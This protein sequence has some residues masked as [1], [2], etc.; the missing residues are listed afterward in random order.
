MH[1]TASADA[2]LWRNT[3]S[4]RVP[5]TSTFASLKTWV[6]HYTTKDSVIFLM[7][8]ILSIS[9]SRAEEGEFLFLALERALTT[10]TA[11]SQIARSLVYK[12]THKMHPHLAG[13]LQERFRREQ[14]NVEAARIFTTLVQAKQRRREVWVDYYPPNRAE[15]SRWHIRPYRFVSNPLSDGFYVLCDGSRD[16]EAYISLSL[17]FDRIQ[18]VQLCDEHFEIAD[19]A[20]FRSH[21]GRA[22]GVWDSARKPVAVVLRFE[23]RHYDRLLESVWHPT[24]SIHTDTDRYV[25]YR[26][27]ISQPE[28]MV[29]WIRSWGSGVVVEEPPELRRRI[30]HSV[31]R[32]T[33]Q[34]GLALDG[35]ANRGSLLYRLWAKREPRGKQETTSCHLLVYHL[36]DVA[37]ASVCMWDK[38]LGERQKAWLQKTLGL[39]AA[40][41]RQLLAL[42]AGLHDIGKA[43]PAFQKKSAGSVRPVAR[44]RLA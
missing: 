15:P 21:F 18:D 11:Q 20:R 13:E 6:Y 44:C 10:H 23:P 27:E 34:Y 4:A 28:E 8:S 40:P 1:R 38:V 31:M 2:K 30:I 39:E 43:T 25:I 14:G 41:A 29:P 33:R 35:E 19:Q 22:W 3:A 7:S 42:L 37:A 5:P 9:S 36:L 26:V 16:G 17:K 12:L 24:Q 32:Q